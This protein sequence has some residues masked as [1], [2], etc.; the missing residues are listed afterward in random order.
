M[1]F[2]EVFET[3]KELKEVLKQKKEAIIKKNLEILGQTDEATIV[4][5]EK[6]DKFKLQEGNNFTNEEKEELKKLAQEI[7][8]LQ[9]NNE[10]L[11]KHSLDVINNI[12]SGILNITQNEKSTY[13]ARGASCQ[14]SE[15]L[16][17]SSI[18]EEA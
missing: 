2:K 18:T 4:L 1:E 17:I 12:L 11:I 16:D 6:I 13:N 10:I 3:Y 7:K 5:C 8:L 14:D 9:E 15:S